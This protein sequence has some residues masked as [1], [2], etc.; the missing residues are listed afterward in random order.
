MRPYA[1]AFLSLL[2]L[3]SSAFA[4]HDARQIAEDALHHRSLAQAQ[5][6]SAQCFADKKSREQCLGEIKALCGGLAIG[7]YCG[8]KEE[9]AA[10]PVKSFQATAKAHLT[11]AQC[12]ET[13]KPYEDCVWDLQTACKGLG[14]GK[15]CGMVHSHA[16]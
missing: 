1:I 6:L 15:D 4:Q 12:M 7:K 14:V 11:A 2:F 3:S 16:Y 9:A 13:G 5:E 8:L 10:D